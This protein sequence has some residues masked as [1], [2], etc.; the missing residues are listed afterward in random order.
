MFWINVKRVIRTG[1]VSFWRN[2]FVSLA[3]VLVVTVT[4]FVIGSLIFAGV[5]FEGSLA[6]LKKKVDIN[7]YFTIAAEEGEILKLKSSLTE[8]PEVATVEYVSRDEALRLF[9]E[10]HKEDY[11]TLQALEELGENPLGARLNVIAKDPS[12]YESI[13]KFLESKDALSIGGAGIVEKVNYRQNKE[14]I[15]RLTRLL[16]GLERVGFGIAVVLLLISLLIT[17]NTIRLVI[18]MS[19]EEIAVMR[20]VGANNMYVRGPF[21][22]G[23]IIYGAMAGTIAMLLFYP[24]T[25]WLGGTTTQFFGGINLFDYYLSNF[26]QIYILLA[27]IGIA[28]GALSSYMAVRKYLN[29]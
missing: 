18:Y 14:V 28:L 12:Q 24:A 2:S 20:L 10:R 26:F 23:G 11:L 21:I 22:V 19:R 6:D 8:L 3:S 9:E 1:I 4:L 13:A 7:I 29:V 27:G 16:Q 15:D 5:I 17:L 25:L